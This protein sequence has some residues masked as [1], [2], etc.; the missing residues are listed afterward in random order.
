VLDKAHGV[1][2]FN[3]ATLFWNTEPCLNL[4]A[5]MATMIARN[6]FEKTQNAAEGNVPSGE[7]LVGSNLVVM[8]SSCMYPQ[9]R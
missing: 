6:R 3:G 1:K 2:A 9:V 7:C 8:I 5:M 4:T